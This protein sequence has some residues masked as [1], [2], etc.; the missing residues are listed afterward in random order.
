MGKA[1]KDGNFALAE[2]KYAAG[3][4]K[5]SIIEN[6][7]LAQ[8]KIETRVDNIAGVKVRTCRRCELGP[9]AAEAPFL[10]LHPDARDRDDTAA[11]AHA[12]L[13]TP[14][15]RGAKFRARAVEAPSH[16]LPAA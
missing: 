7:G 1:F 13:P 4:I 2:V 15:A 16:P 14:C 5:Q 12:Q 9:S 6:V 11:P 3:D 10:T 8:K